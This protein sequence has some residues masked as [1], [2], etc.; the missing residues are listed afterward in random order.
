MLGRMGR[1]ALVMAFL[2]TLGV[3]GVLGPILKGQRP[4][5]GQAA[6]AGGAAPAALP[7]EAAAP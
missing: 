1:D 2:T 7:H 4:G 6:P 3:L 5:P